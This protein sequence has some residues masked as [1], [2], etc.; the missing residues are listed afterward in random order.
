MD[1]QNGQTSGAYHDIVPYL[2]LIPRV[3]GTTSEEQALYSE[4][5]GDS[6]KGMPRI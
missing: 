2:V 3:Q 6:A 1:K 5:Y 4:V